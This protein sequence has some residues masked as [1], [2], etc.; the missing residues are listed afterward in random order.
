MASSKGSLGCWNWLCSFTLKWLNPAPFQTCILLSF[1][2]SFPSLFASSEIQEG[3]KG[4]FSDLFFFPSETFRLCVYNQWPESKIITFAFHNQNLKKLLCF[5][6]LFL[7]KILDLS[8]NKEICDFCI[9]FVK[10]FYGEMDWFILFVINS[11]PLLK[12]YS[13]LA[14]TCSDGPKKL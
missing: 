13:Y 8:Y 7:Y 1:L 6:N 3:L 2:W 14:E 10:L 12:M 9:E 5:F 11:S 4:N